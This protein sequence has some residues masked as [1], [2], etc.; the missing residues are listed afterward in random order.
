MKR[1][2][3]KSSMISSVGYQAATK[4]LEIEFNSGAVWQYA[5]FPKALWTKFKTCDSYG[6]FF[7]DYI[8]DSFEEVKVAR[9]RY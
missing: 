4:T 5:D 2:S 7:R 3:V 9:R 8:Q 6:R 1:E